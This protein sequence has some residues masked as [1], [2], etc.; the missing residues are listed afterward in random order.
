MRYLIVLGT[1]M[2]AHLSALGQVKDA[3]SKANSPPKM[4]FPF[5][6]EQV[7]ILRPEASWCGPRVLY[8]FS[9][10]FGNDYSLDEVEF[11]CNTDENGYT[12]LL[13]LAQ[14]SQALGLDPTPISCS[15]EQ[16]LELG[17]PAIIC[18]LGRE[19]KEG[20]SPVKD[21]DKKQDAPVVHF[22]G[23][24]GREDDG[25]VIFN[26]GLSTG[27]FKVTPQAIESEFTGHAIL[28]RGCPQ[29]LLWP[30]WLTFPWSIVTA[31]LP[32]SLMLA[33]ILVRRR[34]RTKARVAGMEMSP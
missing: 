24:L 7:E 21:A 19:R 32:V 13:D 9:C 12:S 5:A 31:L 10:Y 30:W 15:P 8:F 16:L 6:G 17:G 25:F 20:K 27:C 18:V 26:P 28:L 11:L 1:I 22:V 14:A 23:L 2:V 29:P 4:L 34:L 33:V 3:S